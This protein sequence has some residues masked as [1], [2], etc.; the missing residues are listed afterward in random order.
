M[1]DWIFR[2]QLTNQSEFHVESVKKLH[3]P[4]MDRRFWT[5]QF[6]LKSSVPQFLTDSFNLIFETGKAIN[7]LT[8][9]QRQVIHTLLFNDMQ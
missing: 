2:G 9:I 7:L 5:K 6:S 8:Y 4:Y 1:S 3:G